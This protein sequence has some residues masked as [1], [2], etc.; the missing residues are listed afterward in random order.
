MT[1]IDHLDELR[2][3]IIKVG[4]AF[5]VAA[6]VAWIFHVRIYNALLEPSGLEE[7]QFT[8]LTAPFL[9][10]VKLTLY[11]ALVLTIP[12]LLYQAWAFVAPAVGEVGRLFTY[13]LITLAS[14]LFLAGIAFGYY[15]VLPIATNFLLSW[16][17]DR[18]GEI[19]TADNYLSFATRFLFAFGIGF[20][21]PAATYVGA[22]LGLISGEILRKYRRAAIVVNAVL[23][24]ALTPA[25]VFSMILLAVPLIILY[26]VSILI[27][28]Y[29]NP[30]TDEV[31]LDALVE[32]DEYE[33]NNEDRY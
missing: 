2:S 18:F 13:T 21:M 10:D 3:R 9:T 7:L 31:G 4:A 11:S 15:L 22:K 27:A 17:G 25:D 14:S 16:G 20:E 23:A 30:V 32:D 29:V 12:V 5:L 19:I 28:V 26:E 8:S 33:E 24:A 6:V 1:L